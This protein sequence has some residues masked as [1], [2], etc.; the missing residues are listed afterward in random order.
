MLDGPLDLLIKQLSTLPGLGR[1]SARRIALHMLMNKESLMLPLSK[2]LAFVA[3]SIQTCESCGNLDEGPICRI[4]R[5]PKRDR[6]TI[7]VVSTVADLWAV[8]RTATF[9]GTYH[10]LGG[11][12]SALDG[13][14]PEDLNI[15]SL[16]SN[17]ANNNVREVI[18]A[19]SATVDG[20]STAHYLTDKLQN[21]NV[22]ITK[23]AHGV[24]V[25]G[26]LDYLDDGT[27]ATALKARAS[28]S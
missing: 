5:D 25:G 23:L 19:L 6:E 3:D 8:E 1:R 17:V 7:C 11:V 4:C 28:N 22:T 15:E 16:I 21:P 13:V 14:R 9:R 24:P 20:Q 18:L 12:L 27:I 10:V 2:N 26:E